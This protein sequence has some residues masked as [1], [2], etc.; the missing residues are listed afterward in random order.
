MRQS[1]QDSMALVRHFGRPDLFITFTAN[2]NWEEVLDAIK[3]YPDQKPHD[4]P[5]IIARVFSRRQKEFLAEL[6][7]G[8]ILGRFRGCV[9]TIE[10]QKRGLPHMHLLLF[11][12]ESDRFIEP[13]HIDEIICAELPSPELDQDGSL[14]QLV[15]RLLTHGPCGPTLLKAPFMI[16]ESGTPRCTKKYPRNFQESTQVE[17]DG[18]PIY[19]RR[20]DGRTWET[21]LDGGRTFTCDNRWIVPY[22]PY[23]TRRYEAH[24]NVE[25]CATVKA[26]EYIH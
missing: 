17:E 22:N 12:H 20:D 18:Y 14:T 8:E 15:K 7:Q 13:S 9:W 21:N 1:F 2:P 25:V 23:F 4:R 26:V 3:E 5:D 24:T 6:K 16:K 19:Q 10:Y 11:L